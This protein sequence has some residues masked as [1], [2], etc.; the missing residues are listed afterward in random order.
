MVGFSL[1][2]GLAWSHHE[3]PP[4]TFLL[5][6]LDTNTSWPAYPTDN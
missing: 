6:L 1:L 2:A 4:K 3:I 5:L